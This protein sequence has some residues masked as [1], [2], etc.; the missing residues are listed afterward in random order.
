MHFVSASCAQEFCRVCREPASHKLGEE[1]AFDDP[2]PSR[3]N[4]TSYVCCNH[5]TMIVGTAAGCPVTIP[6]LRVDL[7]RSDDFKPKLGEDTWQDTRKRT[8]VSPHTYRYVRDGE[9]MGRK[10]AAKNERDE[11]RYVGTLLGEPDLDPNLPDGTVLEGY[12][13][14]EE[15]GE[16]SVYA[17]GGAGSGQIVQA[18]PRDVPLDS[19]LMGT[20][21]FGIRFANGFTV[22]FLTRD[23][24]PRVELTGPSRDKAIDRT[25]KA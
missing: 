5:F 9:R 7:V 12:L 21:R 25:K 20:G 15:P 23:G 3:H 17:V 24:L 4:L 22:D 11:R 2:N 16:R 10:L 19:F 6:P 8:R 18:I 13:Y 14:P 1:L